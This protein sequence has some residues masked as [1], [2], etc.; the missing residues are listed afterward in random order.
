MHTA[1]RPS[2]HKPTST[3]TPLIPF[4]STQVI[5]TGVVPVLSMDETKLDAKCRA[6]L[7]GHAQSASLRGPM[8]RL[9]PSYAILHGG[10]CACVCCVC[11]CVCVCARLRAVPLLALTAFFCRTRIGQLNADIAV[12]RGFRNAHAVEYMLAAYGIRQGS[13]FDDE[14]AFDTALVS[15]MREAQNKQW[16]NETYASFRAREGGGGGRHNTFNLTRTRSL[17]P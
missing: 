7:L 10:L 9:L 6:T 17:T 8:Y 11:V 13:L 1:R 4:L 14:P 2:Q 15:R 3:Y 12:D 16:A 5:S